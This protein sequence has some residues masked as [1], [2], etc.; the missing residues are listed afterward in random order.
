MTFWIMQEYDRKGRA[1]AGAGSG[2]TITRPPTDKELGFTCLKSER[3]CSAE[4]H[5]GAIVATGEG[6]ES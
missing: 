3:V 2:P 4:L 1:S 6:K 5:S